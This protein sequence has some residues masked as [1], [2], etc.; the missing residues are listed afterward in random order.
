MAKKKTEANFIKV[1]DL[2]PFRV[3]NP[4]FKECVTGTE[5][6]I[7]MYILQHR[8]LYV[9][10]DPVKWNG[11]TVKIDAA[12][13]DEIIDR[14]GLTGTR[15]YERL[16]T[17]MVKGGI[18]YR[19]KKDYF[20][21]NPWAF[22]K[23]DEEHLYLVREMN[24]FRK[25][26]VILKENESVF[27]TDPNNIIK[28]RNDKLKP[29]ENS[30]FMF[31]DENEENEDNNSTLRVAEKRINSVTLPEGKQHRTINRFL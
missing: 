26:T 17:K 12:F 2:M 22:N 16:I 11:N 29:E 10:K 31:E 21:V 18:F 9:R 5:M 8:L 13:K 28:K 3:F 20:S 24:I 23:G 27:I 7:L 15:T 4:K 30:V 19:I 25:N 1:M 6:M 14:F